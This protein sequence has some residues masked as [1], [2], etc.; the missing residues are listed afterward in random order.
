MN[1]EKWRKKRVQG[2]G[3]SA[4]LS[5]DGSSR[6]HKYEAGVHENKIVSCRRNRTQIQGIPFANKGRR[7]TATI[8]S[9]VKSLLYEVENTSTGDLC[10]L[11]TSFEVCIYIYIYNIIDSM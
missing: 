6:P 8:P 3:L 11:L 7:F 5:T 9:I 1:T 4:A 2:N 10:G